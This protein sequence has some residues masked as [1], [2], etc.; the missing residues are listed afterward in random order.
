MHIEILKLVTAKS[1]FPNEIT[2]TGARAWAV[3]VS[4]G[5][6]VQ[7]TTGLNTWDFWLLLGKILAKLTVNEHMWTG[8]FSTT[9]ADHSLGATWGEERERTP[10]VSA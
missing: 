9:H 2:F 8:H 7:A 6:I 4:L 10:W 5:A 1:L 3:D